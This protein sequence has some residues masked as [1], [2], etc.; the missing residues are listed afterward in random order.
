MALMFSLGILRRKPAWRYAGA[1]A[2]FAFLWGCAPRSGPVP[3]RLWSPECSFVRTGDA[4]IS[5]VKLTGPRMLPASSGA[6]NVFK[7]WVVPASGRATLEFRSERGLERRSIA[8]ACP[9][10]WV[11]PAKAEA[12][13]S[14]PEGAW[15]VSPRLS[16]AQRKGKRIL[17]ILAD[18]LRYDQATEERMPEV[19]RFFQKG[20]AFPWAITPEAWTLPV[21]ASVFTGKPPSQLR[22]ADG[23]LIVLPESETTLAE[24][25][26]AKGWFCAGVCA[27]FTVNHDNGYA[28]G[29]GLFFVPGALESGRAPEAPWVNSRARAVMDAFEDEDLFLYLHYMDMHEPYKDHAHGALLHSYSPEETVT[30]AQVDA[31]HSAYAGCASYLSRAL[32]EV[33]L[34]AE[35]AEAVVL[36]ADHGEEFGEHGNFRHGTSLFNETLHVPLLIRTRSGRE[37]PPQGPTSTRWLKDYLVAGGGALWNPPEAVVSET[38]AHGPVRSACFVGG[39]K[40]NA[41]ARPLVPASTADGVE[42]WLLG[43]Y[44]AMRFTDTAERLEIRP[45]RTQVT[46]TLAALIRQ[47][48]RF[49]RGLYVLARGGES[50]KMEARGVTADGWGWGQPGSWT[51]E[52]A[53]PVASGIVKA[54]PFVLLFLP[55]REGVTPQ[56]RMISGGAFTTP[57]GHAP[58]DV[59]A[60]GRLVWLDPGRPAAILQSVDESLKRLKALGYIQ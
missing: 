8:S 25:L 49:R 38:F 42:R 10:E 57:S 47:F 58:D 30:Q 20:C 28:Q 29:F 23:G 14:C 27:N 17:F 45:D 19:V 54:D 31:I 55:A 35:D 32:S 1:V 18:A 44:P 59:S 3:R 40:F 48:H 5:A 60:D 53:D 34:Q 50:L 46:R 37:I 15:L 51:L 26:S 43:H 12:S 39:V 9:V 4:W 6:I 22:A 11:L 24:A 33:L 41:L 56:V 13:L 16:D 7:A 36:M 2:F 21:L 52:G